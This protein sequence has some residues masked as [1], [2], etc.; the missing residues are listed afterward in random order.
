M[1]FANTSTQ[2]LHSIIFS[3]FH[4][5]I[6]SFPLMITYNSYGSVMPT[7]NERGIT[8][9]LRRV[10]ESHG[11]RVGD[12]NYVFCNDEEILSL[13]RQYIGHD[14]Y[15]DHIGFDYSAGNIL[16]G[17]IYIGIETVATNAE[18]FGKTYDDELHRVIVHGLLHLVGIKDKTSEERA[19][20][21]AAENQALTM[22][23]PL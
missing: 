12:I 2:E 23:N 7:L 9:W 6:L 17:D 22:I 1:A 15:T 10:A 3:F 21:E 16:S 19:I 4:F 8:E 13:N 5:I 18:L 11:R 20:M 14:Y